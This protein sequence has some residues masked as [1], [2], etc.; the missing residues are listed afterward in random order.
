MVEQEP[1]RIL[2]VDDE[3]AIRATLE[4][5]LKRCGYVVATAAN[6]EEALGWLMQSS[7][8]LLLVDLK[9]PGMDGLAFAREAQRCQPAAT[10]LFI[11]GSSDF[12][13]TQVDEQVGY[14]DYI[15]KTASP[16]E[17]LEC[18]AS[19]VEQRS[20]LAISLVGA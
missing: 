20:K 14:F 18:V 16:Q 2:L 1:A 4:A 5:L 3:A 11:T 8:D 7:F 15:L 13:G 9:L 17:V 6:G 19:A 10:I 12:A